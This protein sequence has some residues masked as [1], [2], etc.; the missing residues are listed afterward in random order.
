MTA[1]V[2]SILDGHSDLVT[3]LLALVIIVLIIIVGKVVMTILSRV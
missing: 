2:A 3:V 1:L